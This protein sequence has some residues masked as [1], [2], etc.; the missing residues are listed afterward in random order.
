VNRRP[1]C[2]EPLHPCPEYLELKEV[3]NDA[4]RALQSVILGPRVD[5]DI[6]FRVAL[7]HRDAAF[8][9]ALNH[10]RA[11]LSCTNAKPQR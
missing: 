1:A 10:R 7:E 2:P 11:C 4:I 3:R 8:A 5:A 9:K 6:A